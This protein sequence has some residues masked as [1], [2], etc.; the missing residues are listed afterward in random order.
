MT[1]FPDQSGA[2]E[3]FTNRWK[4]FTL[5]PDIIDQKFE[6]GRGYAQD[7]IR[8]ASE[9]I[10]KLTEVA[11]ELSNIDVNI[12]IPDLTPPDVDE[13]VGTAPV[14]P[15]ISFDMPDD[16]TEADEINDAVR[17]KLLSDIQS[18]A[19]AVP[20]AVQDA[21]FNKDY[22][23]ALLIHQDNLDKIS[24]EWSKRGFTLPD[25]MLASLITQ[26][27]TEFYNK[28]LD[29]SR[30]VAIKVFELSDQNTRFAIEKGIQYYLQRVEVYKAKVQAEAMRIDAIVRTFLG[31]VEIY[32][33]SAQVYSTLVDS[34]IKSFDAKVRSALARADLLIK[35]AEIDMKNFEMMGSLRI[36]AM[37]A[38]GQINAQVA[39]GALASVSAGVSMSANNS[40]AYGYSTSFA[41]TENTNITEETA[42]TE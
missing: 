38:I 1:T 5:I 10:R 20:Q 17:T 35:D 29:V 16:L 28:R 34:K 36:E 18:G 41:I 40:S 3:D 8:Q 42:A 19:P 4:P 6:D 9:T 24:S 2:W 39:A 37:K 15:A 25:G 7:A 32:K 26:A 12:S 11:S 30:D 31:E 22:E 21:I 23:R 14:A 33:G 27:Q 13:F